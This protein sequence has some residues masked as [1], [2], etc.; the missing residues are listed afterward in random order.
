MTRVVNLKATDSLAAAFRRGVTYKVKT[1]LSDPHFLAQAWAVAMRRHMLPKV[2]QRTPSDTGRTRSSW[3]ITQRGTSVFWYST[4]YAPHIHFR[5]GGKT[6]SM[7]DVILQ[8][9]KDKLGVMKTEVV[10]EAISRARAS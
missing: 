2:R 5:D 1:L 9:H 10:K 6:L 3:R 4:P 8:T 7:S